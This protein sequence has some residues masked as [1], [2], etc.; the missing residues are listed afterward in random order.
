MI[1]GNGSIEKSVLFPRA[2]DEIGTRLNAIAGNEILAEEKELVKDIGTADHI[3][4]SEERL[5]GLF[6]GNC[7]LGNTDVEPQPEDYGFDYDLLHKATLMRSKEILR[8]DVSPDKHIIHAVNTI[9]EL[10]QTANILSERLHEWYGLHWPEYSKQ[11][12]EMEYLRSILEYGS[13]EKIISSQDNSGTAGTAKAGENEMLGG[14]LEPA[15][16][17]SIQGLARILLEMYQERSQL[18]KYIKSQVDELTPN[19]SKVAGAII[20]AKLLAHT[21][22]IKRL[23]SVSASTIQLLGAEKAL[24]RHLKDGSS[25]PKHGVIFQHPLL[26]GA[27]HWQRGK[28]ARALASKI[29]IAIKIDYYRGTFL[30]DKLEDELTQRIMDIR[31]KFPKPPVK[32]KNVLTGKGKGRSKSKNRSSISRSGKRG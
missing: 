15:D 2:A 23:S 28:I 26:H 13:R 18:E 21:G 19:C 24:F 32:K 25:P 5:Q 16:L 11:V 8:A 29:S 14:T 12:N 30:G 10:N 20:T 22:G 27:P 1:A 6:K 9:S 4:I 3:I 31:K 17:K 7:E